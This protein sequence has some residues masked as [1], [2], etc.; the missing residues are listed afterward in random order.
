[1]EIVVIQRYSASYLT[2]DRNLN[3]YSDQLGV[4]RGF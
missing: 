4:A 1:M 2:L 3:T